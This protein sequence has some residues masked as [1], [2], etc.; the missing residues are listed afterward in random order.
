MY[1]HWLFLHPS[2]LEALRNLVHCHKILSSKTRILRHHNG[3]K[4]YVYSGMSY[5]NK[6]GLHSMYPKC[7][8]LIS[9]GLEYKNIQAIIYSGGLGNVS[10]HFL[11]VAH[12]VGSQHS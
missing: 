7:G 5:G 10:V 12:Q 1:K 4:L 3:V 2:S 6:F 11:E 8:K 9:L